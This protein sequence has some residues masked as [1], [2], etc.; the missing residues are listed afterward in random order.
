MG[1]GF[2]LWRCLLRQQH[3]GRYNF[4]YAEVHQLRGNFKFLDL[5]SNKIVGSR[6][7][8]GDVKGRSSLPLVICHQQKP[9]SMHEILILQ[10]H[11]C[12]A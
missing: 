10:R 12:R 3:Q 2:G 7:D 5:V 1:K 11:T 8:V 9:G 4:P 6:P